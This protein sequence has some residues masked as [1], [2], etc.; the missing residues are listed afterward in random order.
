MDSGRTERTGGLESINI[1]LGKHRFL[2]KA[3]F[4]ATLP[5]PLENV[6]LR[7]GPGSARGQAGAAPSA[8]LPKVVLK[9]AFWGAFW[10]RNVE[11]H[12]KIKMEL[13]L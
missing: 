9:H 10:D 3:D 13:S 7:E 2:E 5:E 1:P 8:R 11:N 4:S 12:W 6:Y